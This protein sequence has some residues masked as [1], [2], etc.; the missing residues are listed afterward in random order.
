MIARRRVTLTPLRPSR[1]SQGR[2]VDFKNTTLIL[3]SNIGSDILMREDST[4]PDGTVTE[5]AKAA[6]LER[7]RSLYPPELLNRLDEQIIFNSLS[8][9]S[10]SSIVSLRLQEV[11]AALTSSDRRIELVVDEEARDWLAREGYQPRW[12]ARA[13]NRLVNKQVRQP[14]SKALLRGTIR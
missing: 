2:K 13:L 8:P 5:P 1:S 12:G 11:Q 10:I 6:V 9:E 4:E 7:V 14:L 3:T